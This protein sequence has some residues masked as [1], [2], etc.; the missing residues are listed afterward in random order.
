MSQF[1][2]FVSGNIGGVDL[3]YTA[4]GKAK[5]SMRVA[6]N[7]SILRSDGNYHEK[8]TW[9]NCIIWGSVA[10]KISKR[11]KKGD[12]LVGSG[13]IEENTWKKDDGSMARFT[14]LNLR[15]FD[16]IPR[17][18]K[19]NKNR[20]KTNVDARLDNKNNDFKGD[21]SDNNGDNTNNN[22]SINERD[23]DIPF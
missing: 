10:E 6:V 16:L 22:D 17:E 3:R 7:K 19:K 13:D 14:F 15:D 21:T 20:N 1:K 4:N 23:D 11:A 18:D 8:T 2:G 12:I 9:V 5:L